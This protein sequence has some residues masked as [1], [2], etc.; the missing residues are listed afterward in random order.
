VLFRSR[1]YFITLKADNDVI[2]HLEALKANEQITK[3]EN[4]TQA[5]EQESKVKPETPEPPAA[6]DAIKPA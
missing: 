5:T 6:S 1:I 3:T 4:S 2:N